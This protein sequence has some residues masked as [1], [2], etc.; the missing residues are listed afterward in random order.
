MHRV[1]EAAFDHLE[2]LLVLSQKHLDAAA[3]VDG[4]LDLAGRAR[5]R[6]AH[7]ESESERGGHEIRREG[8][9]ARVLQERVHRGG[10]LA[11]APVT[12][13]GAARQL[14]MA[15]TIRFVAKLIV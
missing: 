8:A 3:V 5:K 10:R 14:V 7:D 1:L 11:G 12:V 15:A 6:G 13:E 9:P 2:A 4:V